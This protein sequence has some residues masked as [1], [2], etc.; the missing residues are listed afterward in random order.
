MLHV[1]QPHDSFITV[2]VI[3]GVPSLGD[4][5]NSVGLQKIA[6]QQLIAR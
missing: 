1:K 3:K 5:P 2:V 4:Q 6:P